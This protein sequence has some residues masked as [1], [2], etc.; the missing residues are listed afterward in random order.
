MGQRA[1]L[2]FVY[3]AV[4]ALAG[5]CDHR[6]LATGNDFAATGLIVLGQ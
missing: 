4:H 2:T 5:S 6:V 1:Q 3:R